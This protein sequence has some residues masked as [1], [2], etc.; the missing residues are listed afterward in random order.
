MHAEPILRLVCRATVAG[1]TDALRLSLWP[2]QPAWADAAADPGVTHTAAVSLLAGMNLHR[3]CRRSRAAGSCACA[4]PSSITAASSKSAG[5]AGFGP[6]AVASAAQAVLAPLSYS[7]LHKELRLVR[8]FD[9]RMARESRRKLDEIPGWWED[10]RIVGTPLAERLRPPGRT[11]APPAP[12]CPCCARN[13]GLRPPAQKI[14]FRA[15]YLLISKRA[16]DRTAP[17]EGGS[18]LGGNAGSSPARRGG[19]ARLQQY[20]V[21][22]A[23]R[24]P[25]RFRAH[26]GPRGY[27]RDAG[28][29]APAHRRSLRDRNLGPGAQVHRARRDQRPARAHHPM[30]A[31][32]SDERGLDAPP[33][34]NSSGM[35]STTLSGGSRSISL[36]RPAR[37]AR[38]PFVMAR[39]FLARR[40]PPWLDWEARWL[41]GGPKF[42]PART[43]RGLARR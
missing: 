1:K 40:S 28:F 26:P 29:A 9:L 20:R 3:I 34:P 14:R 7:Y 19:D 15:L 37:D 25:A 11:P 16:T 2:G 42:R 21:C 8:D 35:K 30:L 33:R 39:N 22:V 13:P 32:A 41:N 6:L 10:E 38:P 12:C 24:D 43:G 18:F 4:L 36:C 31:A 17:G 23:S 27:P 5:R